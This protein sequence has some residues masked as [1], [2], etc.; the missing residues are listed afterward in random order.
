MPDNLDDIRA[1]LHR[2]ESK[3]GAIIKS[4]KRIEHTMADETATIANLT[5]RV[6]ENTS[7]VE[8]AKT[9]VGNLKSE[10]DAAIASSGTDNNAALQAL[11]DTLGANDAALADAV[12]QN[13]PAAAPP[14]Q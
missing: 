9:L 11:S 4:D 10:L 6:A 8:S 13:T 1:S 7:V 3:L 2:I 12:V 5:A 14:A